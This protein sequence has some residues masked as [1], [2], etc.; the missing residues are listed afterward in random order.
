MPAKDPLI[1]VRHILDCCERIREYLA[2][3]GPAWPSSPLVLDT[4]CRNITVIGEAA[5]TIDSTFHL[6]HPE[7]PWSGLIGARKI[8]MHAYEQ[9]RPALIQ[10]MAERDIP[11]LSLHCRRLLGE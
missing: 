6:A 10:E 3:A 7:I 11:E 4:V 5:R 2:V 8:V 9:L 1:Y